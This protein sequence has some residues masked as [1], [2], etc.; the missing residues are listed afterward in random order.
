MHNSHIGSFIVRVYVEHMKVT[1]AMKQNVKFSLL[2][3]SSCFVV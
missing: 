3:D 1:V 2:D